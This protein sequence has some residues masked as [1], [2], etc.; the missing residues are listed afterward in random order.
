MVEVMPLRPSCPVSGNPI[1]LVSLLTMLRFYAQNFTHASVVIGQLH[2]QI[3][4]GIIPTSHSWGMVAD[5][6]SPLEGNCEGLGLPATSA[7]IVRFKTM[8]N[9][10]HN[11]NAQ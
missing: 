4:N 9:S 11:Y 10:A 7:Q 8:V 3:T 2:G 5:A 1:G 6:L